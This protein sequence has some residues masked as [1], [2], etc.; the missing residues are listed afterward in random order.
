M[1]FSLGTS[2]IATAAALAA[3][4][5][6]A[7]AFA[8]PPAAP[9]GAPSYAQRT[10]EETIRG[11]IASIEGKHNIQVQDDRGFLDR[12]EFRQGT[13]IN[14]TGVELA[15]GMRV[16]ILGYNNGRTF[17]ANEIDALYTGY[18]GPY[19]AYGPPYPVPYAAYGLPYPVPYAAYGLPYPYWGP[20]YSF[21]FGFGGRGW[22]FRGGYRDWR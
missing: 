15:P 2:G 21:G 6:P 9:P 16:T 10:G 7:T 11:S 12:V 4:L 14:P 5:V 20:A 13:V 8:Q 1:S 18:G 17:A 22:G 3:V 19:A